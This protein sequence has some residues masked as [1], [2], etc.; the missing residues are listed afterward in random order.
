MLL[1][2]FIMA[3]CIIFIPIICLMNY[4][5]D[6]NQF[7][8]WLAI[9]LINAF[10]SGA[11]QT[12]SFSMGAEAGAD[13]MTMIAIGQAVG[14]MIVSF[15]C[16]VCSLAITESVVIFGQSLDKNAF[17]NL[18]Y[19]IFSAFVLLINMYAVFSIMRSKR[20]R[21]IFKLSRNMAR[22]EE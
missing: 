9:L 8:F 14:G 10:A 6:S 5:G 19:F 1:F 21:E 17:S 15:L 20:V 18:V 13:A 12:M 11:N 4:I 7:I 3:I 16:L 2:E 22:L